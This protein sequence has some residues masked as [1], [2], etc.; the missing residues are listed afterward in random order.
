[1]YV[2]N[3][4][5]EEKGNISEFLPTAQYR[6]ENVT[7]GKPGVHKYIVSVP[8]LFRRHNPGFVLYGAEILE[9]VLSTI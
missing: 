9:R 6:V 1:M 2:Y 3:L 7:R 8:I 5:D 4:S